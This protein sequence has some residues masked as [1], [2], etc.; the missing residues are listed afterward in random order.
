[1]RLKIVFSGLGNFCEIVKYNFFIFVYNIYRGNNIM[2]RRGG[3]R[4]NKT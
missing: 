4:V 3:M 2:F 1:M